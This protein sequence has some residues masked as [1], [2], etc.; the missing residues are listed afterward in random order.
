MSHSEYEGYIRGI[1][2]ILDATESVDTGAARDGIVNNASHLADEATQVRANWVMPIGG[3][4]RAPGVS[5]GFTED[6]YY[7]CT[8]GPFPV[9]C[10][11]D[12]SAD[13]ILRLLARSSQNT[14][15]SNWRAALV[16]IGPS[17]TPP[18]TGVN[19][20]AASSTSD[21]YAWLD[22]TPTPLIL[23]PDLVRMARLRRPSMETTDGD[24]TLA[25]AP[26]VLAQIEV[27][28]QTGHLSS[29]PQLAGWY[30]REYVGA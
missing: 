29:I 8:I 18:S 9:T 24:G 28:C 21:T 22:P 23:P 25:Y 5:I 19:V 3:T 10:Y 6:F 7:V 13:I 17:T 26:I 16:P 1:T 14:Q 30:V 2:T 15:T 4:P 27:Y 12:Q 20:A 11:T